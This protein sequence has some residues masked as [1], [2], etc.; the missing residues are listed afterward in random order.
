MKQ[1]ASPDHPLG[2]VSYLTHL[3]V[4]LTK[5][6]ILLGD[7]V[8]MT[9]ALGLSW[10]ACAWL[11]TGSSGNTSAWLSE[12]DHQRFVAWVATALLGLVL[13]LMRYQHYSDRRPLWDE[14]SD[15][16][17]LTSLLALLD[18]AIVAT[19]QWN[20]S[21]LWWGVSWAMVL[22]VLI[23][24]RMLTRTMLRKLNLWDRPTIIIGVGPNAADAAKALR[25]QSEMGLSVHCFV[26]A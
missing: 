12:Q 22:L 18:I 9:A 15:F 19:A 20:A 7:M 13:L 26:D 14:L 21:R 6:A 4:R 10:L 3:Q 8:A 1:T 25:S 23:L 2:T 17:R 16:I 24:G 5:L 11:V